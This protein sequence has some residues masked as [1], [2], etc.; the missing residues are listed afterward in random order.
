MIIKKNIILTDN[1]L[2]TWSQNRN[3]VESTVACVYSEN[4][5]KVETICSSAPS[6]TYP[7]SNTW[8]DYCKTVLRSWSFL[9]L[10]SASRIE[11]C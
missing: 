8:P 1:K 4:S 9:I 2:V 3:C 5:G 7:I 6:C 10:L 11:Q